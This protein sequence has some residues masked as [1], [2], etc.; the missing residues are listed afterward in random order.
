MEKIIQE[1]EQQIKADKEAAKAHE[2]QAKY[3]NE[4]V[5]ELEMAAK[6][7]KDNLVSKAK[8]ETPKKKR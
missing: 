5:A 6:V 2:Q 7:L 3:F 8:P 1:I 4:R